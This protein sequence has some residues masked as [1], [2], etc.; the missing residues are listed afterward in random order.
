MPKHLRV[1]HFKTSYRGD[2]GD[3]QHK[4]HLVGY[5]NRKCVSLKN[6]FTLH[7][8]LLGLQITLVFGNCV[9]LQENVVDFFGTISISCITSQSNVTMTIRNHQDDRVVFLVVCQKHETTLKESD[10]IDRTDCFLEENGITQ[11]T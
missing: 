11:Q 7:I 2:V 4:C 9:N 8:T 5:P 3:A 10:F 6:S 1:W